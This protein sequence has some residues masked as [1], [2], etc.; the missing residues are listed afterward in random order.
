MIA[1]VYSI[2]S[3]FKTIFIKSTFWA[4]Y[5]IH[6]FSLGKLS[7]EVTI[8]YNA[9]LS[10]KSFAYKN[11]KSI[12]ENYDPIFS[13]S[14]NLFLDLTQC[15][16][17]ALISERLPAPRSPKTIKCESV[18]S[19]LCATSFK[20]DCQRLTPLPRGIKGDKNDMSWERRHVILNTYLKGDPP[21]YTCHKALL[22]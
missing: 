16:L 7:S 9:S 5:K 8:V 2:C 19:S 14:M 20:I 6:T 22:L 1:A 3:G 17:I 21:H 4:S 13:T 10:F 15:L 12:P 18:D 11:S